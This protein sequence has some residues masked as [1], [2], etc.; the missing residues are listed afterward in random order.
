MLALGLDLRGLLQNAQ[1]LT[2][3]SALE[4]LTAPCPDLVLNALRV[5]GQLLLCLVD[6]S[7]RRIV[8]QGQEFLVRVSRGLFA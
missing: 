1:A 2:I 4:T 3:A 5:S 8:R 6:R 7:S